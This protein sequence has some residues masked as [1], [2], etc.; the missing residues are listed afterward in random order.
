VAAY[1]DFER[2]VAQDLKNGWGGL[3][4]EPAEWN[5][6]AARQGDHWTSA[7]RPGMAGALAEVL[8][9]SQALTQEALTKAR[10]SLLTHDWARAALLGTATLSA[11][12]RLDEALVAALGH[13]LIERRHGAAPAV[14]YSLKRGIHL[15]SLSLFGSAEAAAR[16]LWGMLEE[17]VAITA[18]KLKL[19]SHRD[20]KAQCQ[21]I[22]ALLGC[23]CDLNN[24]K[25]NDA[26]DSVFAILEQTIGLLPSLYAKKVTIKFAEITRAFFLDHAQGVPPALRDF[27][28]AGLN[29]VASV[30]ERKDPPAWH[31]V[32]AL[33]VMSMAQIVAGTLIKTLAPTVGALIGNTLINTGLKNIVFG[34]SAAAT[35]EFSW[36][37]YWSAKQSSMVSA[38]RSA[39]IGSVARFANSAVHD[40]IGKAW[41]H[42]RLAQAEK[43]EMMIDLGNP[44]LAKLLAKLLSDDSNPRKRSPIACLILS[45]ALLTN[46]MEQTM[47]CAR[48]V[49]CPSGGDVRVA[50][51]HEYLNPLRLRVLLRGR[52]GDFKDFWPLRVLASVRRIGAMRV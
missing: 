4:V 49:G 21:D 47:S 28:E 29:V 11:H 8:K 36:G 20:V 13:A 22:K 7:L 26:I 3:I 48:R 2:S 46:K 1:N 5:L 24:A 43:L 39:A 16:A 27:V 37:D 42:Q 19:P 10:G 50:G 30:I 38:L 23:E 18:P 25:I 33:G 31:E 41:S 17:K 52:R 34:V 32:T 6:Q 45:I 35:G 12:A 40:G 15:S 14:E 51:K 44:S 9:P